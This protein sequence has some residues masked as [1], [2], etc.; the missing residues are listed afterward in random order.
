MCQGHCVAGHRGP[1][2]G[3]SVARVALLPTSY[4]TSLGGHESPIHG[5]PAAEL[6]ALWA[7]VW[8]LPGPHGVTCGLRP[9]LRVTR[10]GASGLAP[11]I[12]TS[13][14]LAATLTSKHSPR[15]WFSGLIS[16]LVVTNSREICPTQVGLE[17]LGFQ[18]GRRATLSTGAS[19]ETRARG[20]RVS[21]RLSGDK[22]PWKQQ[23]HL[24]W[25][26]GQRDACC[27]SSQAEP[28]QRELPGDTPGPHTT[29]PHPTVLWPLSNV[30][31]A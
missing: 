23:S 19:P 5:S 9:P 28:G 1:V 12:P 11:L 29:P 14:L 24:P 27:V 3:V 8:E 2:T 20:P 31:S 17:G 26:E 25:S 21:R 10:V 15:P 16:M 30:P 7:G 4:C 13:V 6:P 22:G 18:A